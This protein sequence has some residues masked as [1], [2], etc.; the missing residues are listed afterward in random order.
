MPPQKGKRAQP[1]KAAKEEEEEEEAAV[2]LQPQE[3]ERICQELESL[4]R[5]RAQLRA[6]HEALL[7]EAQQ[8]RAGSL[9]FTG[10]LAKRA[11]QCQGAAVSLDAERGRLQAE[12][13]RQHR[14]ALACCR[15]QEAALREQLLQ[16]E[17]ELGRLGT[18]LE[19]LRG[20]RELRREQVARIAQLEGELAAAR[21]EQARRLQE[22][23]LTLLRAQGA[24]EAAAQQQARRLA[25][26]A[27]EVATRGLQ[28][29][30]R[31][32]RQQTL[33]LRQ[34]LR[35]LVCRAQEL[36]AHK[37]QLQRQA[38]RLQQEQD[39]LRDLALL[40]RHGAG[41]G[42]RP[43]WGRPSWAA[44]SLAGSPRLTPTAGARS[45]PEPVRNAAGGGKRGPPP[46]LWRS[47]M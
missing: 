28:E 10:Y 8:L 18:Q 17:A 34:E 6:Q 38:W 9:A 7:Q 30:S 36:R 27:Q 19:G 44:A 29:Q 25:Q 45:G 3:Y 35:Q 26:Q 43:P 46:M 20:L 47:S 37:E 4:R 41:A 14:E 31:A 15:A 42:G 12:T 24:A 11:Q 32:M 33:E 21:E 13:R 40:R 39:H 1:A 23:R 16:Q 22:A 2:R 5:R